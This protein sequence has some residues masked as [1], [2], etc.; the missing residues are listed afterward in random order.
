M[1]SPLSLSTTNNDKQTYRVSEDDS[2]YEI[3][4]DVP[5]VKPADIKVQLEQGAPAREGRARARQGD[6]VVSSKQ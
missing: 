4:L 2:K 1:I 5:G 6:G 3:V